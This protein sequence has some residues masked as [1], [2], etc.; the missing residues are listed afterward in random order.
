MDLSFLVRVMDLQRHQSTPGIDGI[1]VRVDQV[2]LQT[3]DLDSVQLPTVRHHRPCEATVV[4]QFQQRREGF[5]ISVV[6]SGAEKEFVFE[7]RGDG[8]NETRALALQGIASRGGWSDVVCLVHDQYVETPWICRMEGECV[9]HRTQRFTG[10]C[11]VDGGDETRIGGPG[12]RMDASRATEPLEVVRIHDAEVQ[13][14]LVPH[15]LLPLDLQGGR[16]NDQDGSR[17]VPQ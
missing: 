9:L 10:L 11:P 4:Q 7:V 6:R 3:T 14:E 16:A 17:A 8:T 12:I 1:A 15:L 13:T 2:G 5:L